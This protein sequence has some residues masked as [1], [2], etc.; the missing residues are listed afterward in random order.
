[1]NVTNDLQGLQQIFSGQEVAPAR[2]SGTL[3]A[4]A[5]GQPQSAADVATLTPAGSLAAQSAPDSDVRMD[6]VAA[7]QQ[8]LAAGTYSVP[9]SAVAD[10]MIGQMLEK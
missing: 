5:A 4:A 2:N 7:V 9:A 6:K 10:K 8:A 3:D 1:M